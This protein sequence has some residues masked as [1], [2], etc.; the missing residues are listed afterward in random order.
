M[1]KSQTPESITSWQNWC[2]ELQGILASN[3]H[4]ACVVL[5]GEVDW[6]HAQIKQALTQLAGT[7]T[8]FGGLEITQESVSYYACTDA[9]SSKNLGHKLGQET[10][11]VIVSAEQGVDANA[12]GQAGG[13]IRAGGILW[14]SLPTNWCDYPNP[15][16]ARFLSYPL[17]LKDSLKGFNRFFWQGLKNQA[18]T[19][20]VLWVEQDH[21]LPVL[22]NKMASSVQ[23]EKVGLHLN[24]DQQTVWS[25]IQSV[26]FGH[27]H[28]PLVLT[29]DRGR[30][31]STL[32]GV[33]AIR[34]LQEGK[35]TIVVTAARLEQAQAVFQGANQ[36]LNQLIEEYNGDIRITENQ[37]GRVCFELSVQRGNK[38]TTETKILRFVAPDDL[39]LHDDKHFDCLMVDEAAHLPLPMLTTLAKNH[40]RIIFASTQHGYEGSGRGFTLRFLSELKTLYPQTKT[41]ELQQPIRWSENDPLENTLNQCL[42]FASPSSAKDNKPANTANL[43]YHPLESA[44]LVKDRAKLSQLF[45]LLTF[46]HYQTAPND[47]MQLLETPNQ[48]LWVA[49][50]DDQ[51]IVAVLF[52]LEEGQLSDDKHRKQGHLF[53]QQMARQTAN[54]AWLKDKTLRIVRLAVQ[55]ELQSQGIGSQLLKQAL[56]ETKNDYDGITTSFGATPSLVDFWHQNGFTALHL[57]Q[58]RDK[59][60]GTHSLIMALPFSEDMTTRVQNQHNTFQQQFAWLLTDSFQEL[61][62]DLILA[63]LV[64]TSF[65]KTVFPDGY[66]AN[67]PFEAVSYQLR[68]WT[69]SHIEQLQKVDVNLRQFWV[70]RILQNISW[71][72]LVKRIDFTSRKQLEQALKKALQRAL[73]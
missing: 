68:D 34:L 63:I 20:Q 47:L 36:T 58:K 59:A 50:A 35:Q 61:S 17:T 44:T 71:E 2:A 38:T 46:A 41:S 16:N 11:F 56:H 52:A 8:A 21:A 4:R 64:K 60:S 37:P 6:R 25:H 9:V 13:M 67:Q 39:V 18:K 69:L 14:L 10:D 1:S 12:L 7:K 15:A 29:A 24:E 23:A 57:G 49:E 33:A 45:Q 31:K 26:A 30:G 43:T 66:L 40:S 48:K 5:V 32:L 51:R 19:Q 28:R 72:K 55:P 22:P 27:R 70:K 42:L 62:A 53:P 54:T 3:Q 65:P 73:S